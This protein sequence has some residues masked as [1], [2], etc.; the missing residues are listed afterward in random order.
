MFYYHAHGLGIYSEI[1]FPEFMKKKSELNVLIRFGKFDTKKYFRESYLRNRIKLRFISDRIFFFWQNIEICAILG[2]K[3]II[4]NPQTGLEKKFLRLLILGNAMAIL[5]HQRGRLVLHAN[6][7]K[8]NGHAV[9]FIGP[10]GSGKSTVSMALQKEGYNLVSDDLLSVELSKDGLPL[11]FPGSPRIKLWPE[12]IKTIC[13]DIESIPRSH[14]NTEKRSYAVN[15]FS[16]SP[17]PLKIIYLVEESDKTSIIESNNKN[18]LIEF[19]KNSY[20]YPMFNNEELSQNFSSCSQLSNKVF[21][22]T[23]KVKRSSDGFIELVKAIENDLS[24][25]IL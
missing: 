14:S 18:A 24:N 25:L 1:P 19:I 6:A 23:L 5:L 2:G 7:V 12:V 10:S 13:E 9:G 15:N 3:E 16:E 20:C 21:F 17:L 8:M 11:S 22:K 4:I